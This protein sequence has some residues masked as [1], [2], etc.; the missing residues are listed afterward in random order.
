MYWIMGKHSGKSI[1][2]N[3]T[4]LGIFNPRLNIVYLL[5]IKNISEDIIKAVEDNVICY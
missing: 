2:N 3:I 4:K 1:F 5:D